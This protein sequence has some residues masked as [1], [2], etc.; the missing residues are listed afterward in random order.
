MPARPA[1][2]PYLASSLS[3]GLATG[4]YGISFG[5]LA[6]LPV[7]PPGVPVLAAALGVLWGLRR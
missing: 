2:R 4:V 3:I 6:L 1:A 5:V 7:A